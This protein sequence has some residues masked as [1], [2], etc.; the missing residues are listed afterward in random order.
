MRISAPVLVGAAFC[1]LALSGC[2]E[3]IRQDM[4]NQ[5]KNRPESPSD[6]FADGR[7]VRPVLENTVARGAISND[8]YNVPK[9]FA[10]FPPAV[11]V[12]GKLLER[13]ED[14]YKIFCTPCHGLQGNGEGM[15]AMR[16][17]KHPPSYHIDRLRQAPNGY[18][19][20]VMSNGFGAMY[21][22]SERITPADRWAIIAYIRALQLSRNAKVADLPA[23]V[24][25][26]LDRAAA[27]AGGAKE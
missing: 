3:A 21:S 14:R 22:Y 27:Q 26:E 8:V 5:P 23:E 11:K 24:R 16:G 4:A 1:A 12:D 17:M 6:F 15:I 10:G 13:G 18:F 2:E 25:Q 9:D 19:Y 20:D 7:S